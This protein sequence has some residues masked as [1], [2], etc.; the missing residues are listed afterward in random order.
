MKFAVAETKRDEDTGLL[1]AWVSGMPGAH[2]QAETMDELR[3]NLQEVVALVREDNPT[4]YP[5]VA[6]LWHDED[7]L[8]ATCVDYGTVSQ[9]RT[10]EEALNNLGE[11]TELY[12]EVFPPNGGES[13]IL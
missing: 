6:L 9:G 11:A 3:D 13:R 1:A 2:T 7:M 4:R 10:V 5:A 8:V 12:L